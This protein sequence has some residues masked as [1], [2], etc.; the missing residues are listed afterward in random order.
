M[1]QYVILKISSRNGNVI[2]EESDTRE[3]Y[4]KR[5]KEKII[6]FSRIADYYFYFFEI[7]KNN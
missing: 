4:V 5:K 6:F 7:I 1:K 3:V 2:S